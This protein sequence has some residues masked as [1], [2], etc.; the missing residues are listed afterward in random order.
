[1]SVTIRMPALSRAMEEGTLVRW[2]VREGDRVR[3]GDLIA[4]IETDKTTME[5]E[6]EEAG[7]VLRL[8]VPEGTTGVRVHTPIAEFSGAEA[9][10]GAAPLP[11]AVA[12]TQALPEPAGLTMREALR[13]ALAEAMRADPAVLLIGEGIA[14]GGAF[15]VAQGLADEFGTFRVIDVPTGAEAMA[16]LAVGAAMAGFRPVVELASF[17]AALPA[18][19][20]IVHGAAMAGAMT[21][22]ALA[23]PVV[24]RGPSGVSAQAGA[25]L[26]H[27]LAGW[28]AQVPGLTVL[29]PHSAADAGALLAAALR[30]PGPVAFLESELLYGRAFLPEPGPPAAIG[31]ARVRRAGRDVTLI[32]YGLAMDHALGA[33]DLLAAE[34]ISAEVLDLGTL[35]PLD[36]PAILASVRRTGRCVTVEEGWPAGG[37]GQQVSALLMQ[38]AFD[39]LAAPVACLA[40]A[41]APMPYAAAL[42]RAARPSA[43]AVAAAARAAVAR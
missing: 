1:M 34:G 8:L 43:E 36:A 24:F 14:G 32:G 35:R 19:G 21:G 38:G 23:C 41:D 18:L 25:Q 31:R 29:A 4:E 9:A 28:L 6:A 11:H 15:R 37:I 13:A 26:S 10:G 5:L 7:T 27:D 30:A 2:L 33:A 40:G 16:G 42:E 12:H 3:P 22:G 20:Q 39:A 17:A